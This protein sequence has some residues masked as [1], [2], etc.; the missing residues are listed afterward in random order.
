MPKHLWINAYFLVIGATFVDG[1]IVL[2]KKIEDLDKPLHWEIEYIRSR[3][4]GIK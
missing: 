4:I 1:K 3:F 2:A